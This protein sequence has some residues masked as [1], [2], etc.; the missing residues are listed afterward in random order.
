MKKY[1]VCFI[2][3]FI[4]A[5]AVLDQLIKNLKLENSKPVVR[6]SN[7]L[8]GFLRNYEAIYLIISILLA[9]IIA[10]VFLYS[11]NF[12]EK[13]GWLLILSGG[14]SNIID[15]VRFNAIIDYFSLLG[16]SKFNLGD[17]MIYTGL[18]VLLSFCLEI[19]F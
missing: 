18:V 9:V 14:I 7:F 4:I 17:I 19:K 12:L 16:F 6:N 8:F 3:A 11:K 13:I 2:Y 15:K 1:F 5:L 10:A